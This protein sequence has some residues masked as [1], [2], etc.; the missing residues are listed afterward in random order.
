MNLIF[1]Y[2][3]PAVGKL[4]V[5]QE[6]SKLTGYKVFHNHVVIDAVSELIPIAEKN[7]FKITDEINSKLIEAVAEYGCKGLI[8][9]MVYAK[10]P[11]EKKLPIFVKKVKQIIKKH[12]GKLYFVKLICDKK[13]IL[14][15]V[16]EESRKKYKKFS[17]PKK[18]KKYAHEKDLFSTLPLRGQF[19]TNNTKKSPEIVAEEVVKFFKIKGLK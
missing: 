16:K 1:I 8:F 18:L 5:A 7:F 11:G 4:T 19:I 17:S 14:E 12:E 3:P 15:R 6:L 10:S 2:G 9:T 13:I